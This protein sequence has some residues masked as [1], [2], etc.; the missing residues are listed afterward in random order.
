M[1]FDFEEVDL[2]VWARI[3]ETSFDARALV[4][5]S[6]SP[7]TKERAVSFTLI[8]LPESLLCK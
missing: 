3:I 4:N 6:S 8:D 7:N 1:G 5:R 2:V